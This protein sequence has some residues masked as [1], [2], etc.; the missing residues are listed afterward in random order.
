MGFVLFRA[1][2]Q[3]EAQYREQMREIDHA[4]S[5][6]ASHER[7]GAL[8]REAAKLS[9]LF[10]RVEGFWEGRGDE[11]AA[12]FARMARDGAEKVREGVRARNAEAIEAAV[13]IV[14]ASCEGCHVRPLDKYR[15][16]LSK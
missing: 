10:E 8:E 14:A 11:E 4:F 16:P 5:I 7:G 15:I 12:N 9:E 13:E 2:I 1:E 3:Y 6:L